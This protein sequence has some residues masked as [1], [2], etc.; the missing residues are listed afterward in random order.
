MSFLFNRNQGSFEN[1]D[2]QGYHNDYVQ[3]ETEHV[4][5]DVRTVGE[6][7]GGHLPNAINIPLHQV[8]ARLDEIPTDKPVILVCATGNRSGTAAR[9]LVQAGYTDVY[10]LRGGTMA[11][12]MNGLPLED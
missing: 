3:A 6:F 10:N 2:V 7:M 1:I 8:T 4:L 12:M 5:V 9:Q 11:W